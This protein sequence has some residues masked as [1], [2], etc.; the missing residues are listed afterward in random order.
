MRVAHCSSCWGSHESCEP[1][2]QAL[3]LVLTLVLVLAGAV[4]PRLPPLQGQLP[5]PPHALLLLLGQGR[6]RLGAQPCTAR[7]GMGVCAATR[8]TGL[9]SSCLQLCALPF[10]FWSTT[11]GGGGKRG[12]I[13]TSNPQRSISH[14]SREH[15]ENISIFY[16]FFYW[17]LKL[18]P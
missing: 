6:A 8:G 15:S 18:I 2:A 16:V 13:N 5:V 14:Q 11:S 9:C 7:L 17:Q 3:Q 4:Q 12:R 10:S 1:A